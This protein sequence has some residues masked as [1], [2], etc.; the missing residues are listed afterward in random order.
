[1]IRLVFA[2]LNERR[3]TTALN[4]L[5]LA[6]AV[7]MLV[8]LLQ[9]ARQS[10]ARF[11][12]GAEGIDL[13]VGAKGSPLQLVMSSVYHLD[14]PTGNIPQDALND[15][16]GNPMVASATPLALG[17]QFRGFRIVGSDYGLFSIYRAELAAGRRFD[18]PLEVVLGAGVAR[19][20]GA[21]LGQ[22][23]VGSHGLSAEEGG[24]GH[25]ATPFT[26][27]GILAPTGKP[28]DRL[29]VTSIESVWDVHGI[30]HE[31]DARLSVEHEH[32]D[33]DEDL[34]GEHEPEIT[35]ILV[36]Y[37]NPAA[38]VRLPPAV[39]RNTA[40]QAASPA[41]ESVRLLQLFEP[42]IEA[43]GFFAALLAATAALAIFIALWNAIRAREG[44]LALL[45]VMGASRAQIF[46]TVLLE[47]TVTALLA[48]GLGVVLA[49]GALS[50]ATRSFASLSEAGIEAWRLGLDEAIIVIVALFLGAVAAAIPAFTVTRKKLAP[51]LSRNR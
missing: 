45:R 49:H 6:I 33:H 28:I 29:I 8:M 42:A 51:T 17:D 34:H 48:G 4:V 30:S 44:D 20:T 9:F 40:M 43:V 7:A 18:A 16:R 14:Q 21:T 23:F 19:E 10:E 2:Y 25:E 26:V 38:A 35:S 37:R 12:D 13:V 5:L 22:R 39:N 3:L 36:S 15:L 50:L 41:R 11:L 46:M 27:T 1:M 47:G 24:Q 32:S 31:D